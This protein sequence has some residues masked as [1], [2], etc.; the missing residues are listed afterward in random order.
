MPVL[1]RRC[2]PLLLAVLLSL[3]LLTAPAPARAAATG[4]AATEAEMNFYGKLSALN[5]CIARAAGVE[6]KK[7]V[8]IAA[9]TIAQVLKG[10]HGSMVQALGS[11]VLTLQQLRNGS[12]QSAVIGAVQMCPKEVP[13]EVVANVKKL[14]QK[15]PSGATGAPGAGVAAPR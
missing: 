6:F 14:L 5:V 7:A 3:P 11:K 9:E 15:K 1:T 12:T 13:A 8:P 4:T 2:R 10:K